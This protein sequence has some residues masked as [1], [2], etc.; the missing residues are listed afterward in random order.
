LVLTFIVFPFLM[1]RAAWRNFTTVLVQRELVIVS[2][3]EWSIAREYGLWRSV[4]RVQIPYISNLHQ[5]LK[6]D[7]P[8]FRSLLQL[9]LSERSS[10]AFRY[11]WFRVAIASG[12]TEAEARQI[13]SA[14]LHR[15]PHLAGASAKIDH[16][17][18]HASARA[19]W[20][21]DQTADALAFTIPVKPNWG[22]RLYLLWDFVFSIAWSGAFMAFGYTEFSMGKFTPSFF[23]FL[24]VFIGVGL[25]IALWSLRE[26]RWQ[27]VGKEIVHVSAS[28]I[29][30]QD[31]NLWLSRPREFL[32]EHIYGLRYAPRLFRSRNYPGWFR[33]PGTWGRGIRL[34]RWDLPLWPQARFCRFR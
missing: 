20:T 34:W 4:R 26:L 9:V 21:V 8:S 14:I 1:L 16:K 27:F 15:F 6:D 29:R 28:A 2:A 32:A 5:M 25:L 33:Q 17:P 12:A 31:A 18:V 3:N 19:S 24:I 23:V 11:K 22:A 30:I 13:V 10:I 7:R